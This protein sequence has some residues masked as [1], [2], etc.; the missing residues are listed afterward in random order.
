M[1][2]PASFV[3]VAAFGI[4][5]AGIEYRYVN[6]YER[7]LVAAADGEVEKPVLWVMLPYHLYLLLPLFVIVS[8]TPS[9]TA[10]A[11]NVFFLAGLED[12]TY[13]AWRRTLVSKSDWT[14]KLMGS[15]RVGP[16]EIPLWWPLVA[17]VA[18]ALFW[19]RI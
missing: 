7:E 1:F 14:T 15:I 16:M 8:Y 2:D 6:K 12:M 9:L 5:Y 17:V 18:A 19:V 10:W 13:F 4:V 11:G 3:R